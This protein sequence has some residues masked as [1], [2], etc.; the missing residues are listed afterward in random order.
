[1]RNTTRLLRLIA[2]KMAGAE[3]K[4]GGEAFPEGVS[5]PFEAHMLTRRY[6]KRKDALNATT[7]TTY[8]R[9]ALQTRPR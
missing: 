3:A 6:P 2:S 4:G 7:Q 9:F 5:V 1:M 8:A